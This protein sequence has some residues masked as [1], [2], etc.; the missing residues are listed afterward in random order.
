MAC[1]GVLFALT[2]SDV[3]ELRGVKE[4]DRVDHVSDVIEER[5]F[6]G[7]WAIETDKSWDAIHRCFAGGRLES[8]SRNYP[9]DHIILCGE[10]LYS[11]SD[12]I[13]SL[14]TPA[15]VKD[16]AASITAVEEKGMQAVYRRID[17][18]EYDCISDEDWQYTW[19][20][21]QP[22]VNFYQRA[23]AAGRYVLFTV[24]Q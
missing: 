2:E 5:E 18:A 12:Y 1:R 6:G 14:K 7:E 22:L 10:S 3:A 16:I 23:A 4:R 15:Q 24:D 20:W 11:G 19:E 13:I 8:K 21:F 9:L 17:P